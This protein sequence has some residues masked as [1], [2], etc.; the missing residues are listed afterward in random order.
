MKPEP[1]KEYS[2]SIPLSDFH[3]MM[4]TYQLDDF[5]LPEEI[6]LYGKET[7]SRSLAVRWL[8]K[9]MIIAHYKRYLSYK[10]ISVTSAQNGKPLLKI[11]GMEIKSKVH[12]S[13]SHSRNRVAA[14]L[15]IENEL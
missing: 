10:D 4:E 2:Q 11:L 3:K 5:F 14:L 13:L 6:A 15:I 9:K 1:Y 7:K 8:L 12:I